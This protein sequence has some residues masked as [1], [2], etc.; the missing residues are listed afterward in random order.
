MAQTCGKKA[1]NSLPS[2]VQDRIEAIK[3]EPRWNPP[4]TVTEY[5]YE[6]RTVYL[7]S[8]P[9]CDQY[10]ELWDSDCKYIC[11]PTGGYTGKGDQ[12]CADFEEKAELVKVVWKD[13]RE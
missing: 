5:R 6:G 9:C 10:N 2:C 3:K 13:E 7:F 12:K 1:Q 11:A 8:S 4:A